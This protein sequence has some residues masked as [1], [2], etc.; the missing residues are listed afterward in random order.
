MLQSG[1]WKGLVCAAQWEQT[2]GEGGLGGEGTSA[3]HGRITK[4]SND[5]VASELEQPRYKEAPSW[6]LL[7]AQHE[8]MVPTGSK[9]K[10][11]ALPGL[12]ESTD[13]RCRATGSCGVIVPPRG[14]QLCLTTARP[15]PTSGQEGRQVGPHSAAVRSAAALL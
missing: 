3:I 15:A 4:E 5:V 1:H 11:S 7:L 9:A 8:Q 6:S 2:G 12:P 13:M 14:G 10:V